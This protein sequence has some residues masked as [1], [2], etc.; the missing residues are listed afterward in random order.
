MATALS[1]R[2]RS[3][4]QRLGSLSSC[5][6]LDAL[7]QRV[8][9]V[10]AVDLPFTF[11]CLGTLDPASGL[12]TSAIKSSPIPLYNEEWAAFEFGGPDINQ[13][14]DIA[15]RAVPV[16]ALSLDTDGHPE[17]CRRFRDYLAPRFGFTDELR[18]ACRDQQTVWAA[19]AVYRGSGEPAFTADDARLLVSAQERLAAEVRRILFP[20][21][22]PVTADGEASGTNAVVALLVDGADRVSGQSAAA[23]AAVDELGGWDHGSLPDS[24]MTVVAS[25]RAQGGS[26]QARV[27]ARSG[28][29]LVLQAVA[30]GAGGDR[31]VVLTVAPAPPAEVGEMTIAARGLTVRETEVSRLVLQ[32][33]STADIA[34]ALHLSPHTVQDHL[35]AVFGK[36]GVSSR[37]EMVGR[38]VL[39]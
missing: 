10:V 5:S 23:D 9:D 37:R 4:T 34:A 6:D 12:I 36:L 8:F 21:R 11:A 26:A 7:A 32:G 27:L 29:W 20:D 31:S 2:T 39:R 17:R 38:F 30:L 19:L 18:L 15:Q 28:R 3:L 35:K 16:A 1:V 24:V 25:A 13:F 22:G 33:A 14:A